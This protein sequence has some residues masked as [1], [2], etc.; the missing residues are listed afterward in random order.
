MKSLFLKVTFAIAF[1]GVFA[2]LVWLVTANI[3]Y[4]FFP[5]PYEILVRGELPY[6]DKSINEVRMTVI[7]SASLDLPIFPSEIRNALNQIDF[8]EKIAI[9]IE[10]QVHI[11]YTETSPD[12][13]R[14]IDISNER[15]HIES[16]LYKSPNYETSTTRETYNFV[17]LTFDKRD[18][19]ADEMEF[20]L[21]N[22]EQNAAYV[23]TKIR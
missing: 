21:S 8:R 15:I 5:I 3:R 1:L 10:N 22:D 9:I 4:H 14:V 11:P 19:W 2:L 7:R 17:I 23:K 20:Y 13:R 16:L 12:I 6:E 18:Q